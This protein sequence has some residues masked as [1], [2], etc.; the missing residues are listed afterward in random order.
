[1]S[2]G[3][4]G[5]SSKPKVESAKPSETSFKR[6]RGMFQKDLQHMMYGYGDEFNPLPESVALVEDIVVEY[7]TDLV[8]KA[9][10]ISSKRGKLLTEDFLFLMRKISLGTQGYHI[11]RLEIDIEP[12]PSPPKPQSIMRLEIETY[13]P[14]EDLPK[15]N[16]CTEL[17]AMNEELK[18]AR[19]AF[20]V[21]EDKL[22]T[23]D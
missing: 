12:H 21:D 13:H 5:T 20:D 11:H 8:H 16:R 3:P 9:Q 1:M 4:A 10:D 23:I 6:K 2:G 14:R 19:K 15:L 18:Q 17:L 7:V 22:A